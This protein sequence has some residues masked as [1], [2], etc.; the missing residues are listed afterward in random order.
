MP[1]EGSAKETKADP[2]VKLPASVKA[3]GE[4]ADQLAA[5]VK[6]A[7]DGAPPPEQPPQPEPVQEPAPQ[8]PQAPQQP[9]P[10]TPQ[11]WEHQ[12]NSLRGRYDRTTE[13]NRRMAQQVSEMQRLL[14]TMSSSGSPDAARQNPPQQEGSGVRFSG[15][16]ATPRVTAK[17]RQEFGDELIDVM[18][19]RAQEVY[20]P[21]VQ[22]MANELAQLKRQVGGVQ[23][24]V[25]Y[26]ARSRM[27]D[28]FNKELPNWRQL[29]EHPEFLAWLEL[30][31]G[32]SGRIRK[33]MLGEAYNRNEASRVTEFFK[34][35][36]SDQ[37]VHGPAGSGQQPGNGG[38][39]SPQVDLMSLA[40]PGRAKA[41]QTQV[42]PEKP[43]VYAS[44]IAQFYRDASLGRYKGR[45][46]EY[47]LIEQQI[48]EAQRD[49]RIDKRR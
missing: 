19:R 6:A 49:N 29:N 12:F 18:G 23:N 40:A 41:G 36:L 46:D 20:E 26:D 10:Q 34:R 16:V 48:F 5:Q 22:Q 25:T 8:A 37:A 15:P 38:S 32:L 13:D 3:A 17:E 30:P 4:R 21:Y 2:N 9:V 24:H 28:T 43:L 14:A 35:F 33:D 45:D 1:T 7:R 39:P 27:Y 42:T 11:D 44:E 47:R 31:D